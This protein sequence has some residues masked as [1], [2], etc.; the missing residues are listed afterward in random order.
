MCEKTQPFSL[1]QSVT[2]FGYSTRQSWAVAKHIN[3]NR[4]IMR[5][6]FFNEFRFYKDSCKGWTQGKLRFN[7]IQNTHKYTH[8][9]TQTFSNQNRTIE[10][11][12]WSSDDINSIRDLL[13]SPHS[14]GWTPI[15]N[16]EYRL[17]LSNY[18]ECEVS[19][20]Y[21]CMTVLNFYKPAYNWKIYENAAGLCR[22]K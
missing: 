12:F 1:T 5:E 11:F 9:L 20:H 13:K 18:C 4:I 7:G 6:D 14:W 22:K 8:T 10:S 19:G 2:C 21:N 17:I 16:T 15:S 3:I